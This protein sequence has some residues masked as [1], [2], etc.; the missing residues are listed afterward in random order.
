MTPVEALKLALDKEKEAIEMYGKF[1][2]E[3]SEIKDVKMGCYRSHTHINQRGGDRC[4]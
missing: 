4:G 3:N 1:S 2:I